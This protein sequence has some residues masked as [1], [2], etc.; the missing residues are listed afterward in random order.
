MA[1]LH[2]DTN[3]IE[4]KREMH[5]LR[6]RIE[7][8]EAE[9]A[10]GG[11]SDHVWGVRRYLRARSWGWLPIAVAVLLALSVLGAQNKPEA[12]FID[13]NGNTLIGGQLRASGAIPAPSTPLPGGSG[14]IIGNSDIYFAN[15]PQTHTGQG[16]QQGFAAIENDSKDFNTLMILGR[17]RSATCCD[18]FVG[19]W[20]K[21]GIGKANPG[22]SLDVNG[23]AL[24][25]G[26]LGIAKDNPQTPL[27]VNG[28][29]L[30]AGSLGIGKNNPQTP[31]DVKGEIRGKPWISGPYQWAKG[32]ARVPMTR[33]DHSVCFLTLVSGYF[34][35]AG[36]V[37]EI[38]ED[39]GRWYLQGK[40]EQR[41]VRAQARCIG[42]PDNS[43]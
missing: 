5:A 43:W 10:A 35:G 26:R 36:E 25:A 39:G 27:D 37:V 19:L 20:D 4:M 15:T 33:S 2:Q 3:Y 21:V 40:A 9:R 24:V 31:L 30:V 13:Q 22:A 6:K 38:V 14:V 41:D 12:L 16:N 28:N 29:A 18:R 8:L 17:N 32:Q 23:N 7:D 34:Y 1:E 11:S 42:A